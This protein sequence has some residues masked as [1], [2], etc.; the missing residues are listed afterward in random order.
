MSKLIIAA[1]NARAKE[2]EEEEEAEERR[3]IMRMKMM[4]KMLTLIQTLHG[5]TTSFYYRIHNSK[6]SSRSR[7]RNSIIII[8]N[9]FQISRHLSSQ[10]FPERKPG[11]ACSAECCSEL[12]LVVVLVV[13]TEGREH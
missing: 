3:S 6:R 11:I 4:R 10:L 13:I 5:Q 7:S 2:E 12:E 8:I 1:V 9:S